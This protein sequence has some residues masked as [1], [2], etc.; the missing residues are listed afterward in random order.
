MKKL[1]DIRKG[2]LHMQ[3][4]LQGAIWVGI[5]WGKEPLRYY[6]GIHIPFMQIVI[7]WGL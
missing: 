5:R 7:G 4:A 6:F 3:V 1:I 2:Q